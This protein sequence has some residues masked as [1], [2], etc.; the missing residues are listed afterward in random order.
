M[1]ES[2]FR[3]SSLARS[4]KYWRAESFSDALPGSKL[5][6]VGITLFTFGVNIRVELENNNYLQNS[7]SL[8]DKRRLRRFSGR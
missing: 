7:K 2:R 1:I 5:I 3:P 4:F 8:A 6:E